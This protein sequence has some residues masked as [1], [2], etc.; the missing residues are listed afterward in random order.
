MNHIDISSILQDFNFH[1]RSNQ[2]IIL[3]G[4]F[5]SGKS[6]ML[7]QFRWSYTAN[8]NIITIYPINYAISSNVDILEYIKHDIIFQLIQKGY[9][10]EQTDFSAVSSAIFTKENVEK[11]SAKL[12]A[13]IP[14]GNLITQAIKLG[15][16]M[17]E[18]YDSEKK[19][20][21]K[22]LDEFNRAGSI[23]ERDVYTEMIRLGLEYGKHEGKQWMLV[24]E[25]LDRI[26]PHNIFRL[27]NV[28]GSHLDIPYITGEKAPSNK[29]GF[30]KIV[31]VLDYDQ[32]RDIY[33]QYFGL[34]TN[35]SWEGYISKFLTSQPFYFE[36][37][38]N[39]AKQTVL[40]LISKEC[41]L[42]THLL[43]LIFS[44]YF[45][46]RTLSKVTSDNFH[47]FLRTNRIEF[48]DGS[49]LSTSCKLTKL[50][51][52]FSQLNVNMIKIREIAEEAPQEYID[53]I[54]PALLLRHD[55]S[56]LHVNYSVPNRQN[57]K[58]DFDLSE[59]DDNAYNHHHFL[60]SVH[61]DG[62]LTTEEIDTPVSPIPDTKSIKIESE[63]RFYLLL[64]D[65]LSNFSSKIT[66]RNVR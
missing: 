51:Y 52:Y 43:E 50:L 59:D 62:S 26:D 56:R 44:E 16:E 58:L 49:C 65:I 22:Y 3:S 8:Y 45:S 2:N 20:V 54:A 48:T 40:R 53:L 19:T 37:V 34:E 30:D 60:I 17:K 6:Y 39:I 41:Q 9:I 13:N 47:T 5:G 24:I 38:A 55:T 33:N 23:Y 32:T 27:L 36:G 63:D 7:N 12:L 61:D 4:A 28:F 25:D 15:L 57:E 18:K 46:I 35:T 14:G 66:R 10:S 42:P 64:T 11:L 31:F 29:F 1:V 21:F